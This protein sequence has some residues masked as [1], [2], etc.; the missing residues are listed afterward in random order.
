MSKT[1]HARLCRE[2]IGATH[3]CADSFPEVMGSHASARVRA[4]GGKRAWTLLVM[5]MAVSAMDLVA[6]PAAWGLNSS[7]QIGD[8]TLTTRSNPV[9]VSLPVRSRALSA[10]GLNAMALTDAGLVYCWGDNTFGQ[11]GVG[12]AARQVEP[13]R[14]VFSVRLKAPP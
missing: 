2:P 6:A 13:V 5:A 9:F 10:K 1:P 3:P 7:G 12:T 4:S 11:L 14:V 8:C